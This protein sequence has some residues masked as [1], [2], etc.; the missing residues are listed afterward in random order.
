MRVDP[1]G[2]IQALP[3]NELFYKRNNPEGPDTSDA[4]IRV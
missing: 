4:G 1:V 2:S 3:H